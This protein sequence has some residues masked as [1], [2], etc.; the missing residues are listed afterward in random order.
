MALSKQRDSL[1][2]PFRCMRVAATPEEVVRQKLL[3]Y[4]TKHLGYP[5]ELLAVEKQLSELPHLHGV[6]ALP[7]RRAD[8]LCFAKGLHPMFPLYPLLLIECKGGKIGK[9]AEDQ[10]IGYNHFVQAAYVAIAG[11]GLVELVHPQKLSFLPKYDELLEHA[12]LK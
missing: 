7:K 8:I 2:D 4:M 10:A 11:D 12:C 3:Q 5:R 6:L 1:Y 9:E